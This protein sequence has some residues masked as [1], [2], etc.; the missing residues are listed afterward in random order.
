MGAPQGVLIGVTAQVPCQ[1]QDCGLTLAA[2][3]DKIKS[4]IYNSEEE[5]DEEEKA[6]DCCG[7]S[8]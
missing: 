7:L 1:P 4:E 3:S 5:R 6:P 8:E 2:V